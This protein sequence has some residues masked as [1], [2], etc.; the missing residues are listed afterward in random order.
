M[1]RRYWQEFYKRHDITGQ[2]SFAE[3]CLP[4]IPERSK[5]IDLGCGNGRD[6]YYFARHGHQV[7][8]VDYAVCPADSK[9]AVFSSIPA[10]YVMHKKCDADVVYSRFYLHSIPWIETLDT[11]KWARGLFM[12]EF[13]SVGDKPVLYA[14]HERHF[15]DGNLF[16]SYM[17]ACGFDIL[18]YEK[19]RGLAKYKGEDPLI[20]RVVAKK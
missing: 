9:R 6:S 7:M 18:H 16:M 17:I 5:I 15:V 8:G 11:I 13:R 10:S 1:S 14:N 3:W 19:G 4:M 12:A 2:T 20:I